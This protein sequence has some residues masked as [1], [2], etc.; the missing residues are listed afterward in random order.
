MVQTERMLRHLIQERVPVV[1]VINK[2]DRLILELK[3]PPADAYFKLRHTLD[4]INA[5][6]SAASLGRQDMRVSPELGNVCFASSQGG[7]SFT[8]QSFAKLYTD[9]YGPSP[10]RVPHTP[11]VT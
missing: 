10:L 1:V 6:I 2:V 5:I 3:L 9:T 8:V 4:E 11:T 7:W